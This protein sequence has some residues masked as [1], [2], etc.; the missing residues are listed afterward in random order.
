MV[1]LFE[2]PPVRQ[3]KDYNRKPSA[4]EGLP[5]R[6][7]YMFTYLA[8]DLRDFATDLSV[9]LGPDVRF[10]KN[11][12]TASKCHVDRS[13][14]VQLLLPNN[15]LCHETVLIHTS[16]PATTSQDLCPD[17]PNVS[18]PLRFKLDQ[19]CLRFAVYCTLYTFHW[20]HQQVICKHF[21]RYRWLR[22]AATVKMLIGYGMDQGA[23]RPDGRS[24]TKT[25]ST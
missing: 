14:F 7:F 10:G 17:R 15:P 20:G 4:I 9:M 5:S 22:A 11:I 12:A 23:S 6:C 1:K 24:E 8:P 18:M 21:K 13:K 3:Q 2:S 16:T 25:L 19:L